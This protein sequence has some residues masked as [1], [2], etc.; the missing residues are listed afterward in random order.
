ME[1]PKPFD[2]IGWRRR[3]QR[4]PTTMSMLAVQSAKSDLYRL[5]I[6]SANF[7]EPSH[8]RI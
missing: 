7:I 2:G 6:P 8:E 1:S 3:R 4:Q 5:R